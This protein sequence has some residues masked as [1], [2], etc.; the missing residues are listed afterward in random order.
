MQT[1]GACATDVVLAL[2]NKPPEAQNSP[3]ELGLLASSLDSSGTLYCAAFMAVAR[4]ETC[5]AAALN[6]M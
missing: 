6:T 1:F 3:I 5:S 2:Q 4:G